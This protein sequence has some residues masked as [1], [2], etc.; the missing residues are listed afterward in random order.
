MRKLVILI[1][2]AALLIGACGG[3]SSKSGSGSST[4]SSKS[5]SSD[6]DFQKFLDQAGSERI[7]VTYT[8]TDSDG[9][10]SDFTVSQD[11]KGQIAYITTDTVV[12]KNG[13]TVTSCSGLPDNTECTS[14]TGAES[15]A[16]LAPFTAILSLAKTYIQAANAGHALGD[17][18]S[19]TIAG[20][21]A[22]CV[23]ITAAS[24]LG[25]IGGDIASKLGG[26]GA[27]DGIKSC[28][29]T[30]TGIL[31]LW[32]PVGTDSGGGKLEATQVGDPQD[33]DF[34]PPST[35]ASGGSGSTDTTMGS[36]TTDTTTSANCTPMTL[37]TG[38]TLPT[39]MTLPCSNG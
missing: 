20:R 1:A 10:T 15:T 23:T 34:T 21:D 31:L 27:N 37:P 16:A 18:S 24:A 7:R 9:K 12:I 3:S 30:Q 32:Q 28:V 33:S 5:S 11:G 13:D 2:A 29:D 6:D 4:G 14:L 22:K 38:V 19:E 36:G 8:S 25:K 17:T 26:K 39:G 35:V